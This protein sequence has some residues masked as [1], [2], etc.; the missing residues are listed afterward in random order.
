MS[1]KYL[2]YKGYIGTVEP[3][4]E[5]LKMYGKIEFIND[6]VTYGAD[7]LPGLKNEF[8]NAVNDYLIVCEEL[9]TLPDKPFSG[10]F[11]VRVGKELHREIAYSAAKSKSNINVWVKEACIERLNGNETNITNNFNITIDEDKKSIKSEPVEY[12]KSGFTTSSNLER[13]H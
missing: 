9:N 2:E 4:L 11:N 8:E 3:C 5:T 13:Q 12:G 6:L 1:N 10:T 7:S